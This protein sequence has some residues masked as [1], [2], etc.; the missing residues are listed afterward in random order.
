MKDRDT[1]ATRADRLAMVASQIES[2]GIRDPLVV[3]A[4]RE[5]PRHLF[6]PGD[7][8]KRAHDDTPLPIGWEQTI[9]QPYIVAYMTQALGLHGQE[10]VLEIG[11]GSGYQA[12]IL[13]RIAARVYTVER[14]PQLARK[15]MATLDEL[16]ITNIQVREGDGS[17]GWEE[18]SPFDA[19]MV[20]A[21]GP[22]IP[23]PLSSQLGLHGTLVMPVGSRGQGQRIVRQ[24][25]ISRETFRT[26]QL[27]GVAFVPLIGEYGWRADRKG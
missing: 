6:V 23:A 14:I 20:T 25:R 11:C 10:T 26:D 27:L 1:P 4:M 8:Q 12:A 13:S 5:V 24:T 9:S 7:M 16:G 21:S 15:A 17:L 19:I 2:R 18:K 3:K 22:R